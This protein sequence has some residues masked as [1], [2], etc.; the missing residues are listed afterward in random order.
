MTWLNH[1]QWV[2]DGMAFCDVVHQGDGIT[3]G[4]DK[5]FAAHQSLKLLGVV[6]RVAGNMAS[7]GKLSLVSPCA[8]PSRANESKCDVGENKVITFGEAT[9]KRPQINQ[10]QGPDGASGIFLR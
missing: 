4:S 2:N 5:P 8:N 1:G 6:R 9:V 3:H 10:H 7:A